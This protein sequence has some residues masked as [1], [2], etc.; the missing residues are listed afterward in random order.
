MRKLKLKEMSDIVSISLN[1][2]NNRWKFYQTNPTCEAYILCMPLMCPMNFSLFLHR[3]L[4][5]VS[6]LSMSDF[7]CLVLTRLNK[8]PF[9][10]SW[11]RLIRCSTYMNILCSRSHESCHV[12]VLP[13]FLYASPSPRY[14]LA[15]FLGHNG[16]STLS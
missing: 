6:F 13:A 7:P 8:Q 16:Q 12:N 1:I 10:L 9:C 14:N 2:I 15:D 11:L 3:L 4:N 5:V